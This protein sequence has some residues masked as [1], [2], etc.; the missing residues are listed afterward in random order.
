LNNNSGIV[1]GIVIKAFG[2][3]YYVIDGGK[4]WECSLRGHFRHEKQQ[5]LVGD[6][7]ELTPR[8]G[9]AGVVEKVLPRSTVLVRPPVAN[10]DQAVMVFALREPDPNPGLVDRFLIAASVNRIE[11]ILCFNKSDLDVD[12]QLEF[13]ARYGQSFRV[14]VT[15]AKTGEGLDQLREALRDRVSVF[16]GPS[17]VGKSTMLNALIPGLKLKTG[18][19]S[20]KTKRGK[21]TTRH[22]ELITLPAGGLVVDTP[23]FSSLDLPDMKQVDLAGHFPEMAELQGEC[24]FTGCLHDQEPDCAVKKAVESGVIQKSRHLQYLEFLGDLKGRKRF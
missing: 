9:R 21:H 14:L 18:T 2:G 4:E 23:G 22:V 7:V 11:P 3:F 19:I 6:R 17:G 8:H 5:V 13:I 15:S 24:Y 10:V 20:D 16:A 1:E 12:T